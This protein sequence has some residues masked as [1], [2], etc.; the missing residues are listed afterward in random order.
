MSLIVP[1]STQTFD[2]SFAYVMSLS[3]VT[4][5][6]LMVAENV[7]VGVALLDA[8]ARRAHRR[9]FNAIVVVLMGIDSFIATLATGS[10][11]QA[12]IS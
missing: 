11:I 5:A 6:H 12:V 4:A 8:I 10:L 1:L 2:L 3:G 7:T 9:L